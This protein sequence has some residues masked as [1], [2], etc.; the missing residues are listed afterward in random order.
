MID[1][2]ES[3]DPTAA[4]RTKVLGLTMGVVRQRRHRRQAVALLIVLGAFAGGFATSSLLRG[5]TP[6]T[7]ETQPPAAVLVLPPAPPSPGSLESQ[8]IAAASDAERT[9]L[10]RTAGDRYLGDAN[11]VAAALRCYRE[12]LKLTSSTDRA[13]FD[14]ADTWLLAALKRGSD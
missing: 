1:G 4:A 6:P 9:Q 13:R 7:Q 10:L 14:P 2:L 5:T 11:D 12:M 3:A 8:A